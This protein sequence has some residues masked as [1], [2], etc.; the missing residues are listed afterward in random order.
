MSITK[1]MIDGQ[2]E[3]GFKKTPRGQA[4][5]SIHWIENLFLLRKKAPSL[6]YQ[7]GKKACLRYEHVF[8]I[9]ITKT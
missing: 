3:Q 8:I 9:F 2:M 5:K 7:K 4:L 1:G 6:W